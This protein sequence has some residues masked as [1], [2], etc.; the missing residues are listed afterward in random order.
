MNDEN[1]LL[2]LVSPVIFLNWGM[3]KKEPPAVPIENPG[4]LPM[5]FRDKLL[6]TLDGRVIP[7][8]KAVMRF[9]G[10]E[11]NTQSEELRGMI[12][13]AMNQG[14]LGYTHVDYKRVVVAM[15]NAER[16]RDKSE[17]ELGRYIS[18]YQ[19]EELRS[20]TEELSGRVGFIMEHEF[21]F[22]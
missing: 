15:T 11:N 7:R 3:N 8:I 17:R 19:A 9:V 16:L 10:E 21:F 5:V 6:T 14:V 18:G 4:I 22:T 12:N 2:E 1:K 13:C 20:F